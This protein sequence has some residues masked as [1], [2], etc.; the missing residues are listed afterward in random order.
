MI[1]WIFLGLAFIAGFG[2]G[3]AW[4][5]WKIRRDRATAERGRISISMP[6]DPDRAADVMDTLRVL[7]RRSQA[8]QDTVEAALKHQARSRPEA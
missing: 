8:A 4:A 1:P 3:H 5:E 6:M 7:I 2:W